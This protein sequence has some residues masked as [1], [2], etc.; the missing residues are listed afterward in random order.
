M[1]IPKEDRIDFIRIK[2]FISLCIL[3]W[4]WFVVS[5]LLITSMGVVYVLNPHLFL[6]VP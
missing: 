4:K 6:V 3:N 1:E 5:I 2:D